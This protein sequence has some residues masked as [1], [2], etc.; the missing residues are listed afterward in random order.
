MLKDQ[1]RQNPVMSKHSRS[2]P[3]ALWPL[4]F[5]ILT[6]VLSIFLSLTGKAQC[7]I[8]A[9]GTQMVNSST[10]QE[11]LLRGV[12]LGDW[13]LQEGYML[14]PQN[15]N[16]AGT[17]WA[18]KKLYYNQGQTEAQV[19]A[20]YLNW[21]NNF[22]T[23]ADIDYIASLGFNCVRLPMHYELFLT[24]SQRSVRN[25]VIMNIANHDNYKASLQNWY[26]ANQ[27]FND[28]G[29]EGFRMIDN[30]LSWCKANNMYVVLDLHAAPGGQGTDKNIA[31]IFY[32]NNLWQFPVFQDV[33]TRLWERLSQRYKGEP[34]IAMYDILNE[35]N[36]VPGG[37]QTIRSLLQRLIS[38][39]RN[40]GDNH[41]IMIEGNGWGNNYDYLEPYNFSPN[42][43][44]V[45]NAHRYGI[46][47]GDDWIRDPNPNQ[48]NRIINMTEFR[49]RH[50]V[51]VWVGESGENSA[52]WMRQNYDKM[53]QQRIGWCHWTYKRHDVGENAALMRIGGNYPTDGASAMAT[54]LEQ[55]KYVN[56]IK[57]NNS[58]TAVVTGLPAPRTAGCNFSGATTCSGTYNSINTNIEAEAWCSMSGVQTESSTDTGGGQN[59]GYIDINDWMAY[60]IN[61]PTSG[62]YTIQYRVASQN[63]GGGIRFER[64]GGGTVFGSIA[65]PA[66]NGWQSWTTIQH[67]VQLPA[68]QQEVA[69]VATSAGFNINWF[70]VNSVSTSVPI[71]QTIWLRGSNL[72]YVSSENGTAAMICNRPTVGG[73]EQFTVV[74][75]GSGLIALRGTNNMYVSSENAQ[76]TM[77]CNRATIGTWERFTWVPSASG[78]IALRGSNNLYV[79][80]M[81]GQSG[82]MC[83]RL[84]ISGWEQ[85]NWNVVGQS[86]PAA[87][88]ATVIPEESVSEDDFAVY[89]NPSTGSIR[90]H[91]TGRSHVN[92]HDVLK[93]SILYADEIDSGIVINNLT[94]GLYAIVVVKNSKS[95]TKKVVVK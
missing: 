91:V 69:I 10:G 47:E 67:T 9:R 65:V 35:P 81:N 40:Q 39:I 92:V 53:N 85:F 12:N 45:Y 13:G 11:V 19:E 37:G 70:R 4:A 79:S 24:G 7:W 28:T 49:T 76:R 57:N 17:Q 60:R 58:I 93:G 16:I 2:V 25:S 27:L 1:N 29:A 88:E 30:L 64:F 20:F 38:A 94:P 84:T 22:V 31:D 32:E 5:R 95:K 61:V 48:I 59:V 82:M 52:S 68:G 36:N 23:K 55:I 15:P 87:R 33:T 62:T 51:P 44:L 56:N 80:S 18:M 66:T 71:G 83:D 77:Q 78:T 41:M 26:N 6:V 89:P 72:Q 86:T 54:V 8:E 90:I 21:R 63:G 74:D 75:A 43:G 46:A 42:W 3:D 50:N 73:W 34:A 14:N